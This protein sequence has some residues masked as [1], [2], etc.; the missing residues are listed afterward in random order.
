MT[1]WKGVG[2]GFRTFFK[3]FDY[4]F[5]NKLW[6]V[7]LFP[8]LFNLLLF[9]GGTALLDAGID[10]VQNWILELT[11]MK[12]ADFFMSGVLKS[13]MTGMIWIILKFSFFFLFAYVGG[14]VVLAVMSPV[15]AI[16]S[17]KTEKMVNGSNYP[18]NGE[19]WMRD[20]VRGLLIVFRNLFLELAIMLGVFLL[21]LIPVLGWIIALFSPVFLFFVSAYFYGFSFLDYSMERKKLSIGQ[22]VR[23]I[24][25]HKGIVLANGSI[26]AFS[27]MLPFCGTI[28]ATFVSVFCVVGATL[29]IEE[30]EL[31]KQHEQAS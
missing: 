14:Y 23:F 11:S 12:D 21:S 24:R 13:L 26:F 19:Q 18:F 2:I 29:A 22:S 9:W 7:L 25:K 8:L 1:F 30:T 3:A 10:K 31:K 6:W 28:L 4:V 5:S 16:V 27:L 15:F 17:E 20:M